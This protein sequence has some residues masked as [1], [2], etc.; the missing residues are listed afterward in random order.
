MTGAFC[1]AGYGGKVWIF[2][3]F[4]IYINSKNSGRKF[5]FVMDKEGVI[6]LHFGGGGCQETG[7]N[8]P[9]WVCM[10]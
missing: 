4:L 2:A 9:D 3:E 8:L 7:R 5:R 1:C 6:Y 10:I